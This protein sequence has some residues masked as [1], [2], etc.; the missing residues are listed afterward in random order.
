MPKPTDLVATATGPV[1][2][3]E[4][5]VS[6]VPVTSVPV[7]EENVMLIPTSAITYASWADEVEAADLM[8]QQAKSAAMEVDQ[9][10]EEELVDY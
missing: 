10:E 3:I 2:S 7:E 4:Y 1:V 9:A 6:P 5:S 8:E